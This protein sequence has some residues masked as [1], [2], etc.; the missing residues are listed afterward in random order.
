[1]RPLELVAAPALDA[2]GHMGL[3]E[4]LLS[5]AREGVAIVRFYRWAR[6]GVTFGY[7]Q[8]WELA[9]EM[10][11][12]RGMSAADI[13]RRATGG[14]VVFHDG[15]VTFSLVFPWERLSSPSLIYKDVHRGVHLGLK[16]AGVLSRIWSG[17]PRDAEGSVLE[18]ACFAGEPEKL[19]LVRADG[20][21]VLGGA[22]RRRGKKGLYQGSFRPDLLAISI[23]AI[24]KAIS[25]GLALEFG[26]L[27]FDIDA[28]LYSKGEAFAEKY[29]SDRWNKRR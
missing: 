21:K 8:R 12:S 19:D 7:S 14:G 24:Q 3:D 23:P 6:P 4:A 17:R 22:L 15:D 28:S 10:A 18:K 5:D 27:S 1:M 13:V 26:A 11:R 29:R 25:D 20:M 2:A 9:C 16:A